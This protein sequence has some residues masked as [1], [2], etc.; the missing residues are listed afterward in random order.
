[1]QP[2]PFKPD[3]SYTYSNTPATIPTTVR[4]VAAL[5]LYLMAPPVL[6]ALG[7]LPDEEAVLDPV[8]ALE[9]LLPLA[10]A[11]AWKAAKVLLAVGLTAK[12]I[13]V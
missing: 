13:P 2:I 5:P 7:V 3:P 4:A 8:L 6:V 12:T 11:A 1:M 9:L 10:M